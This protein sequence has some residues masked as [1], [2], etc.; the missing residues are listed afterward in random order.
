MG[1]GGWTFSS[2]GIRP[3]A[4][5]LPTPC[6]PG[7]YAKFHC[8]LVVL[9]AGADLGQGGAAGGGRISRFP[10]QGFDPLPTHCRHGNY[11]NSPVTMVSLHSSPIGSRGGFRM[12]R[13][14]GDGRFPLQGF[15]P[16]PTLWRQYIKL[17][18][19]AR[20]K[21]TQFF[22]Q[23]FPKRSQKQLFW[24]LFHFKNLPAAQKNWAKQRLFSALGELRKSICSI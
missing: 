10:L 11:A 5:P 19:G 20:A 18:G 16:L 21:K 23:D 6:R 4:D 14:G 22:C 17:S 15:D 2:S 3:P 7:N 8:I 1:R 12:G 9:V 13:G 24:P